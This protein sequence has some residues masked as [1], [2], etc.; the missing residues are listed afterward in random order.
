MKNKDYLKAYC[1]FFETINKDTQFEKYNYFFDEN[2]IFQ[3][4]FQK[5]VGV[6]KIYEVF[7]DMYEVL[8]EAKFIVLSHSCDETQSFIH[9][10]FEYKTKKDSD[11]NSFEGVSIVKFNDNARVSSHVDYWDAASNIYEKIP[12]LGFILRLIKKKISINE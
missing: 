6:E 9:W 7:Q 5:V 4:P 2:S 3:D 11:F 12:L 8:Y 1:E 10:I